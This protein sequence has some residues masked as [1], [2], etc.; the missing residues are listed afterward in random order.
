MVSEEP[1]L[2]TRY[3]KFTLCPVV[4]EIQRSCFLETAIM[5]FFLQQVLMELTAHVRY[6]ADEQNA[7]VLNS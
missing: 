1:A 5:Y 2:L 3:F 7:M 4:I 6:Q